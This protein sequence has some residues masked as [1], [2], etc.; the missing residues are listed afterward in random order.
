LEGAFPVPAIISRT[1]ASRGLTPTLRTLVRF[2]ASGGHGRLLSIVTLLLGAA[3]LAGCSTSVTIGGG[4]DTVDSAR[5]ADA[6]SKQLREIIPD[7][8]VRSVT[9]PKGVKVAE[10]ATFQCTADVDAGQLPIDVT[11][12]HVNTDTGEYEYH[13]EPAAMGPVT[14]SK[15]FS[16]RAPWHILVP[17]GSADAC[18]VGLHD[19]VS[20]EELE[21]HI[22]TG[23]SKTQVRRSGRFYLSADAEGSGSC[24]VTWKPGTGGTTQLPI[25]FG[26]G[27][28][29]LPFRAPG[30]LRITATDDVKASGPCEVKVYDSD[31]GAEIYSKKEPKLDV[32]VHASGMVWVRRDSWCVGRVTRG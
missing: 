18:A 21:H 19:A 15:V 16:A 12:S 13:F 8:G 27:E 24:N 9:C 7:A 31:N 28:D 4:S 26:D 1:V 29:T 11:L 30:L 32:R 3:L 14:R 25:T 6:I 10:G 5:I 17:A 2:P 23:E 22:V 20:G